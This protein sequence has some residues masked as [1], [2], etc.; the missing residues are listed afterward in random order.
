MLQSMRQRR[1]EYDPD[2]KQLIQ[3]QGGTS[4]YMMLSANK[5]RS[6]GAWLRD[7]LL[8]TSQNKPWSIQPGGVPDIPP[9]MIQSIMDTATMQIQQY[10]MESGG[11]MSPQDIKQMLLNL[12]DQATASVQR[13]A[14]AAADRMEMKMLDQLQEGGFLNALSDFIDDITTFP[15]AILKGPVVRKKNRLAWIEDGQGGYTPD[16]K[17]EMV[18]EWE[19]VDPFHAS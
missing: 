12:K 9:D 17:E 14:R 5:A 2:K 8:T 18:L 15:S 3:E 6:A 4:I 7:V 1:G 19:R 13:V 11:Q 10:E 16:V